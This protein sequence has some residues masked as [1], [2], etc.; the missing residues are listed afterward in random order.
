MKKEAENERVIL[1]GQSKGVKRHNRRAKALLARAGSPRP[2]V[3]QV[4]A[5]VGPWRTRPE[6]HKS[7]KATLVGT[8]V[9][10]KAHPLGRG[11]R[12]GWRADGVSGALC[13]DRDPAWPVM[14]P[15]RGIPN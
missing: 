9:A 14:P 10:D 6:R 3:R 2:R 8:G 11:L 13:V 4:R 12:I 1:T 15:T 5:P 7:A